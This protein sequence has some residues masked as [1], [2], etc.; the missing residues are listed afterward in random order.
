MAEL[1]LGKAGAA[2]GAALLPKGLSFLGGV[3]GRLAG[4]ALD[5]ADLHARTAGNAFF[6][7]EVLGARSGRNRR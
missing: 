6:V 3:A 7:T 1:V 4:A 5:A 2:I